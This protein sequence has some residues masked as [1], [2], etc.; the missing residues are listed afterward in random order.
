MQRL[1]LTLKSSYI[2]P[3]SSGATS[4]LVVEGKRQWKPSLKMQEQKTSNVTSLFGK[5]DFELSS[6]LIKKSI[7][8]YA[9]AV[10]RKTDKVRS[11]I[12]AV[13]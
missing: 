6:P 1:E 12:L 11:I 9:D 3:S 8:Q 7:T 13:N 5:S 10:S 4:G 2:I